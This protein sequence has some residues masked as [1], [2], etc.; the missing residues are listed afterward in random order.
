MDGPPPSPPMFSLGN[1][2]IDNYINGND[3]RDV[4]MPTDSKVS[5]YSFLDPL[6]HYMEQ[7]LINDKNRKSVEFAITIEASRDGSHEEGLEEESIF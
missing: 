3:N 6:D 4:D 5:K 1:N 7:V 2:Y